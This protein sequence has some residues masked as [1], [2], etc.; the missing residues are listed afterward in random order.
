MKDTQA[1]KALKAAARRTKHG[2][3]PII[4]LTTEETQH[5]MDKSAYSKYKVAASQGIRYLIYKPEN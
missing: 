2:Q 3:W 5:L 4:K 1:I